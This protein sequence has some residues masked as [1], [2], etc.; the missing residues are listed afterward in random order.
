[1][2]GRLKNSLLVWCWCHALSATRP[3]TRIRVLRIRISCCVLALVLLTRLRFFSHF[4]NT[5]M[6]FLPIHAH[7]LIFVSLLLCIARSLQQTCCVHLCM[8]F[9]FCLIL[10]LATSFN[11]QYPCLS[12]RAIQTLE[13]RGD[14]LYICD[15]LP[16]TFPLT[17]RHLSCSTPSSSGHVM[18]T[19]LLAHPVL[20]QAYWRKTGHFLD[21]HSLPPSG[22]VIQTL[23]TAASV[24]PQTGYTH[25][26]HGISM[27]ANHTGGPK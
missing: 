19:F 17:S 15:D 9:L 16:S 10:K 26:A 23:R 11:P 12:G 22:H 14:M 13:V 25:T 24:L 8:Q 18:Q 27:K 6:P 2:V 20:S 4:P 1:M 7:A 21:S 3:E 5:R